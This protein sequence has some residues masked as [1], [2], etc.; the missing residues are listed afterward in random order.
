[1]PLRNIWEAKD[2]TIV[3]G[4]REFGDKGIPVQ[5]GSARNEFKSRTSVKNGKAFAGQG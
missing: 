3:S 1:M 5:R 4:L 2:Q